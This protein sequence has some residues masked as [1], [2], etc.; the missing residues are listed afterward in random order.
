MDVELSVKRKADVWCESCK[1]VINC[2]LFAQLEILRTSMGLKTT[3]PRFNKRIVEWK[4][5]PKIQRRWRG[6]KRYK[7][8]STWA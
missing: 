2:G 8:N 7:R 3:D 4:E 6:V 5:A 1:L